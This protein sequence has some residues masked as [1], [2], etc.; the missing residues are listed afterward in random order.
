M[1]SFAANA[2]GQLAVT[3]SI[4]G[5]DAPPFSIGIYQSADGVQPTNLVGTIDV[6]DSS[7]LVGSSGG[8][9]YTLTYDGDLN[10]LD[11]GQYYLARLDAYDQVAETIKT[12]NLS[13]PLT[14]LFQ[15]SD[16]S[17]Y[18]LTGANTAGHAVA[19]SQDPAIGNLVASL[20]GA[21]KSSPTP[22]RSMWSPT[23]GRTRSTRRAWTC[24]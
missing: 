19:F 3:Y 2:D 4:V 6:S 7:D 11:G 14:G 5:Q 22:R 10:G 18:A 12:D 21:A 1:N 23:T 9:Q 15:D 24:P 17:V 8:D 16:G 20:D 13:A